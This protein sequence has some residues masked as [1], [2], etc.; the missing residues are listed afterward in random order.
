MKFVATKNVCLTFSPLSFV[1]V[2]GSENRDPGWVKNQD[3]VSRIGDGS[4]TLF[5]SF[6]YFIYIIVKTNLLSFLVLVSTNFT[7]LNII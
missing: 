6:I 4:A 7:K 1:E 3:L 2:Y 5:F